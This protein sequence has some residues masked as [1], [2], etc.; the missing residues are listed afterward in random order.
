MKR[1]RKLRVEQRQQLSVPPFPRLGRPGFFG[2]AR[3]AWNGLV[4][5]VVH[6]RNMQIH[7]TA[8]FLVSLVGSGIPLGLAEKVTM[9]FCVLLVFFAEI[10]NSAL[11]H[12]VDLATQE[13]DDKAKVAKDAAAAGVLVL[14]FGTV[15]IFATIIFHN[16]ETVAAF[17]A[18]V[19]RQ[20]VLGLPF[21]ACAA[22]L[23]V[24]RPRPAW[25]DGALFVTAVVLLGLITRETYS[26]V[27]TA[28]TVG[29]LVLTGA[30]AVRRHRAESAAQK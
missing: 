3:H 11:E 2:S 19:A 16:R 21:T 29:L 9:V 6:Q 20:V 14:A 24:K 10:L 18:A 17:Q 8:A 22:A 27:F 4:H 1:A 13:F 26:A 7:V 5:T 15:V 25:V 12:L 30:V 23:I 28:M